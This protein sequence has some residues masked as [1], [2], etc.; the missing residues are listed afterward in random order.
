[1]SSK[2]PIATCRM[3]I[4]QAFGST[5]KTSSGDLSGGSANPGIGGRSDTAAEI[6]SFGGRL[7]RRENERPVP[8]TSV[9]RNVRPRRAK[10]E[11]SSST[12]AIVANHSTFGSLPLSRRLRT[13]TRPGQSDVAAS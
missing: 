4:A 10:T 2:R 12:S 11:Y 1:M 6:A 8:R 3:S 13:V 5:K 9:H 7:P